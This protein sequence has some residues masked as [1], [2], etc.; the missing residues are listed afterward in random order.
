MAKANS[1]TE[2]PGFSGI[3][4]GLGGS[5]IAAVLFVVLTSATG[6][7]YHLF[8]VLIAFL[9][10]GLPRVLSERPVSVREGLIA[11]ILG[12]VIVLA[13]WLSLELLDEMPAATLI[14]DQPGGVAGE[15]VLFGAIGALI[16]GSWG[17][18]QT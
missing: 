7:T 14:G 8:P 4:L 1:A 6:T 17:A 9:P 13:V 5:A 11:A 18:R 3:A 16:G 15:F 2:T 10:A 12:F